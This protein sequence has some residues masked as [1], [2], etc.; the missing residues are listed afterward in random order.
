MRKHLVAL[1]VGSALFSCGPGPSVSGQPDGS[2]PY[3]YYN[4]GPGDD[5]GVPIDDGG[6]PVD[7]GLPDAGPPSVVDVRADVNRNG[8]VDLN[9]PTEDLDE[10]TWD[11]DHGAIF[12][13]N[14]DDDRN[15]CPKT[16]SDITLAQCHDAADEVTNGPDDVL[17][18]ARLKTAAWPQ[19]PDDAVG[20][21][22]VSA[23]AA[24]KV[25]LFLN[26]GGIFT[27][28]RPATDRL[29][30]IHLRAGVELAIE[31]RDIVRNSALWDGFADITLTV[32]ASSPPNPN[33]DTVR[34]KLAPVITRHHLD[35]PEKIYSTRFYG[36]PASI[37]FINDLTSA[38]TSAQITAPLVNIPGNDQW[39]QDLFE[40]AYMAMPAPG[41]MKVMHI[42]VRSANV[43][44]PGSS[45]NPLRASGKAVFTV[46]RGKDVAGVQQYDVTHS[47]DM[48]TL[49][50]FGNLETIPPYSLGTRSYPLGR[51]LRGNVASF[52]PDS[53]MLRLFES[54]GVQPAVYIDTSWLLVAHVDETFTFVKASSPRGWTIAIADPALARSMLQAQ[55][56]AGKGSTLMF[57]GMTWLDDYGNEYPAQQ[58]I[59]QVLADPDVMGTSSTAAV[60][61]DAQLQIF[62]TET[63]ITDAEILHLPTLFWQ[64]GGAAVAYSV[65]TVNGISLG[66]THYGAPD[67]HGPVINGQDLWKTQMEAEL[68]KVAVT[69]HW[70]E[71]WD[72]YH[73]LDGE[74][75]CG[76]NTTRKV[77]ANIRWWESGL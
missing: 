54:Q 65:G 13:A 35:A 18:L 52:H 71:N 68:A 76:S 34:L 63:G 55:V 31:G 6:L 19:A 17:D 59:S 74:V 15:T 4:P 26:Q 22:S 39:T 73:R 3:Y 12:L 42:N 20:T 77:P 70:I 32:S 67:P 16:G 8:T 49:D 27:V 51:I 21:I 47:Q 29:T 40:T 60:R 28:F 23:A 46:M 50:S 30:A 25:R 44:S 64:V 24:A 36:D 62:K 9:D 66:D 48:D 38:M 57:A 53:T 56:T 72:D 14:L 5:G 61:I 58:T 43:E 11:K 1:A 75:H 2:A 10:A 7:G 41:G 33:S 45:S 37:A 69:V